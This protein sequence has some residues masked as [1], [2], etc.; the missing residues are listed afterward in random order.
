MSRD[1][2]PTNEQNSG[3]FCIISGEGN[4]RNIIFQRNIEN[5]E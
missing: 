2:T 5:I 1:K 3:G 4:E